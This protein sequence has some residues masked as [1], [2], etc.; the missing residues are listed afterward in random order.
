MTQ[1]SIAPI[2]ANKRH[3]PLHFSNIPSYMCFC[4]ITV[5]IIIPQTP[6]GAKT[7]SRTLD[8]QLPII[9][10]GGKIVFCHYMEI[11]VITFKFSQCKLWIWN[12]W[13]GFLVFIA[14]NPSHPAHHMVENVAMK[15]PIAFSIC[16]KL[17][18]IGFHRHN[19]H[20]IF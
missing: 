14:K 17:D 5:H 15:K 1:L 10:V 2:K 3:Q 6:L 13:I 16:F 8:H 18:D 11:P 19:I 9:S 20:H 7:P 12:Q 4:F